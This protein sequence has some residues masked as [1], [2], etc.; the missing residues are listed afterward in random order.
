[1]L[2]HEFLTQSAQRRPEQIGLVCAGRRF[3]FREL[4]EMSN[5]VAQALI[6]RGVRRGERVALYLPNC[7]EAVLGVFGVLKAG[8]V[9]VMVNPTT[10]REKLDHIL[11]DCGATAVLADGALL[12]QFDESALLTLKAIFIRERAGAQSRTASP[13]SCAFA[14]L[15]AE[16]S[17]KAPLSQS[18]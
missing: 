17:Q 14:T 10:K 1:M 2:V 7:V 16:S 13:Q 3:S 15:L 5:Q 6:Q 9:F 18:I 11:R 12:T 4:D 8:A